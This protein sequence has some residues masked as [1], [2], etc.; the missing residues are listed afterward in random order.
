MYVDGLADE[1]EIKNKLK[2][3]LKTLYD[4]CA[5]NNGGEI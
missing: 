4:Q 1:E 2:Q 3:K 5:Y